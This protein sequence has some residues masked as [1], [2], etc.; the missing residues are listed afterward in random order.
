MCIPL[1]TICYLFWPVLISISWHIPLWNW[2]WLI[3]FLLSHFYHNFKKIRNKV[4]KSSPSKNLKRI[5]CG[6]W[7]PPRLIF[8]KHFKDEFEWDQSKSSLK[9]YQKLTTTHLIKPS[10]PNVKSLRIRCLNKDIYLYLMKLMVLNIVVSGVFR[11]KN[12]TKFSPIILK[13]WTVWCVTL[14]SKSNSAAISKIVGYKTLIIWYF[15][16]PVPT[17]L[18]IYHFS[19][20]IDF[21]SEEYSGSTGHRNSWYQ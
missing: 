3:L 7:T 1:F 11:L 21:S 14:S 20:V 12:P 10:I 19:T 18:Y 5:L 2:D 16:W 6:T 4:W 9:L 13:D 8:W 17:S 15:E